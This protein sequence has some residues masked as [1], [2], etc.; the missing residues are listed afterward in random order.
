[1]YYLLEEGPKRVVRL[2]K[3]NLEDSQSLKGFQGMV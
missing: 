2:A 3:E 1:M